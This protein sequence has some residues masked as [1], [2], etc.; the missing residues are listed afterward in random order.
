MSSRGS[1]SFHSLVAS[2]SSSKFSRFKQSSVPK[3]SSL[4]H[5]RLQYTAA[6]IAPI[7]PSIVF[8]LFIYSYEPLNEQPW[9]DDDHDD[10]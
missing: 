1:L 4:D 10:G 2:T 5:H 3:V 6:A 9:N 7:H 8:H